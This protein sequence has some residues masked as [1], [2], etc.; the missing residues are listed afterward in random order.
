[1]TARRSR[2]LW[3]LALSVL[4]TNI[5]FAVIAAAQQ[6]QLHTDIHVLFVLVG[7]YFMWRLSPRRALNHQ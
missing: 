7:G 4:V 1:M 2:I 5:G 3:I 6:Q